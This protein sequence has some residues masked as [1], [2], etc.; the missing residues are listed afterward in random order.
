MTASTA[1]APA[2]ARTA[3]I[4]YLP[5]IDSSRDMEQFIYMQNGNILS[6][7]TKSRRETGGKLILFSGCRDPAQLQ[8]EDDSPAVYYIVP[9]HG[10]Q[11]AG[12]DVD[13]RVLF[14]KDGGE[15]DECG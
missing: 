9:D 11:K 1:A 8:R 15:A 10:E 7:D 2:A 14:E 13:D 4:F 3:H 6:R 12:R 5:D